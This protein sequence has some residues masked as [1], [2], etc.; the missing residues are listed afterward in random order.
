MRAFHKVISHIFH[1]LFIPIVG[2]L[3]YFRVTPKYTPLELQ[4]GNILPIFILTV[5]IPII[6]FFILKNIGLVNSI[7]MPSIK[8]RKYPLYISI[9]LLLM[10]FL[11]VIPSNFIVELNYYFLGLISASVMALLLLFANFKSSIHMMGM[12]SILMFLVSLSIHFEMNITL[13]ISILTLATGLVATSRLYLKAH[14]KVELLIG[15]IIG[16]TSQLLTV[17]FWI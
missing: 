12:G 9:A 16:F 2:T 17:R 5:I 8:E 7:F 15:F 1:P 3:I 13:G 10:V 6:C 11:K 14:N 4:S